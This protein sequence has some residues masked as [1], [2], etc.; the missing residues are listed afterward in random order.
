MQLALFEFINKT[1]E[2]FEL[3]HATYEYV[4]N[5]LK[6]ILN[7]ALTKN[8][9]SVLKIS[10]RIKNKDSLKEKL[11]RN[12]FYLDYKTSTEALANLH[13]LIGLSIEC[14]FISDEA[15][16]YNKLF[17]IFKHYH[18]NYYRCL[19]NE[20]V[21]L[22]LRMPQPQ[23]QRNG[24]TIYRLDGYYTF[25]DKHIN[26]ELQIKSLVHGFWS[27]VEHQVVYKNTN[28][29]AYDGFMKNLLG[30]IRDCLDVVDRQ[31][32]IVY[33]QILDNNHSNED[34][35]MDEHNFKIFVAKTINDLLMIKLNEEIGFNIDFKKCSSI[36]SQYIYINDFINSEN[37]Q[38]KMVDYFEHLNFL[39]ISDLTFTQTL[40]L[41]RPYQ[42]EDPFCNTLGRYFESIMNIDYE[43]HVFFVMLFAIQASDNIQDFT[44]FINVIKNLIIQPTWFKNKFSKY[45][46]KTKAQNFLLEQL[47]ICMVNNGKINIIH[48]DNLYKIMIM[49]KEFVETLEKEYSSLEQFEKDKD[50]IKEILQRKM[51]SIF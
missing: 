42:N 8:D 33:K 43:W 12:K 25:N 27:E 34:I 49:F 51:S 31:L 28:F 7:E 48:E 22:N 30:T 29:V 16:I 21:F 10:S 20:N 1:I 13:D 50:F 39:R 38:V 15:R 14:R 18:G 46:D 11:I 47:A 9:E 36:L 26:F 45:E 37:P 17:K 41:E 19:A 4:E 3:N 2:E 6:R 24:F 23:L 35:G 40:K 44:Q 32:E 5:N